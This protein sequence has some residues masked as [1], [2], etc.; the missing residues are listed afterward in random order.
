MKN[1]FALFLTVI[2]AY[3]QMTAWA[4]PPR[5]Y[6]RRPAASTSLDVNH[7]VFSGSQYLRVD[8]A[9]PGGIADSVNGT[10]AFWVKF[11]GPDLTSQFIF[12]IS[13]DDAP[14]LYVARSG[15]GNQIVVWGEDTF[16][17]NDLS[18][19]STTGI[20]AA[21]GWT[22][23]MICWSLGADNTLKRIYINGV[24][25]TVVAGFVFDQG[26][27]NYYDSGNTRITVGG[28]Y[29]ASPLAQLNG[30][31]AELWFDDVYNN[32]ISDYY[33]VGTGKAVALGTNGEI[34]VTSNTP[35]FYYS[36][37]GTGAAW[38]TNSGL[39]GA[40]TLNSGSLTTDPNPPEY[41]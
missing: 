33:T 13:H 20:T 9:S 5:L 19:R 27:L 28:S 37:A 15:T 12:A 16:G 4:L 30:A 25:D 40:L 2:I 41:P 26:P 34:P 3:A 14:R 21:S 1:Y 10:I 7:A 17:N 23:V 29:A 22:H 6:Y 32:S 38:T 39:G 11:N 35:A 8:N 24:S 31:I 18:L 36:G